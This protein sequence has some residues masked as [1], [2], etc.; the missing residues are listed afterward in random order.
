MSKIILNN[1]KKT[2]IVDDNINI[3]LANSLTKLEDGLELELVSYIGFIEVK[4]LKFNCVIDIIFNKEKLQIPFDERNISFIKSIYS[5]SKKIIYK[6]I[7]NLNLESYLPNKSDVLLNICTLNIEY[8]NEIFNTYILQ[9]LKE[10]GVYYKHL[11]LNNN[12][13]ENYD[14]N[15]L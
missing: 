6:V 9:I 1:F 12:I 15:L 4:E 10:R 13:N 11:I 8:K 7:L 3:S 5:D 14:F 2:N